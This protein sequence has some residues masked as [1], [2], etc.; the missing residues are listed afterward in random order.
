M[1]RNHFDASDGK[2]WSKL[3]DLLELDC[4]GLDGMMT[5]SLL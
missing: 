3:K 2:V 5:A 1:C 4:V